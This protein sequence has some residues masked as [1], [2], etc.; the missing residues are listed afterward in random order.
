SVFFLSASDPNLF[1]TWLQETG[2]RYNTAVEQL[3]S[4]LPISSPAIPAEMASAPDPP[5]AGAIA[6][7]NNPILANPSM[8]E[9]GILPLRSISRENGVRFLS[10]N[11]LTDFRNNSC[12]GLK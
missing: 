9:S 3:R 2:T 7:P 11:S 4:P 1:S 5:N 10:Q 12:S 6:N 8:I